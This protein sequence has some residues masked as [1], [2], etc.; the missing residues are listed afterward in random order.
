LIE[1]SSRV[2][3]SQLIST[4]Q[5]AFR[6]QSRNFSRMPFLWKRGKKM[7]FLGMTLQEHFRY[8]RNTAKITVYDKNILLCSSY[9]WLGNKLIINKLS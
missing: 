4:L 2:P 7:N 8:S 9:S 5:I 6:A 1:A 3:F